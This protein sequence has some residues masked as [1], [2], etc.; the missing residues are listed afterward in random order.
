MVDKAWLKKIDEDS[1]GRLRE[2]LT[3]EFFLTQRRLAALRKT[4]VRDPGWKALDPLID[5]VV[6]IDIRIEEQEAVKGELTE[7]LGMI[8]EEYA[9][10]KARAEEPRAPGSAQPEQGKHT[11]RP[12]PVRQARLF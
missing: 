8:A 4:Q 6:G 3:R 1:L 11:Q 10:R 12:A 2:E 9:R 5:E 7:Q